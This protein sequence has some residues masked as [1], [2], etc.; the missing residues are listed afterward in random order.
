MAGLV[1]YEDCIQW[2][3][4]KIKEACNNADLKAFEA[5]TELKQIWE[6][7]KGASSDG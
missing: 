2:C 6:M 1:Q 3:E 7:K 4:D 5:Y